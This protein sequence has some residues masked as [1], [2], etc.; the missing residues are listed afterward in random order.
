MW[1]SAKQIMGW[2]KTHTPT[3]LIDRSKMI[4]NSLKI[5]ECLNRELIFKVNN[6]RRTIIKTQVNPIENYK[7]KIKKKIKI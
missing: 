1:A 4:T 7:K 6:I 2:D 5:A 3:L